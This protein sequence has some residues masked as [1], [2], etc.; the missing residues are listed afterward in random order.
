MLDGIGF[1]ARASGWLAPHDTTRRLVNS[2]REIERGGE[3]ERDREGKR[4]RER[5]REMERE[6]ERG[7][8][9]FIIND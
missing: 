3:K 2:E 5:E 9:T 6:R 7:P 1:R 4:E 8:P